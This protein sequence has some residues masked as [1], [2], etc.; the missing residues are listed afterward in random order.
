M[1]ILPVSFATKQS[2]VL[3]LL[4]LTTALIIAVSFYLANRLIDA[5]WWVEHTLKVEREAQSALVCLMDCE[6]A[7]RGFLITGEKQYLEP[8]EVCWRHVAGHVESLG[9]LTADNPNQQFRIPQLMELANR[10]IKF[11]QDVIEARR[12]SPGTPARTLLSLEPGRQ[13]MDEFRA[14]IAK[15]VD[16]EENLL[17][18]RNGAVKALERSTYIMVTALAGAVLLNLVWVANMSRRFAEDTEREHK[19]TVK[20]RNDAIEANELK[21]QFVS[22]ISHEIRTPMS[23]VLGLAEV[24]LMQPELSIQTKELVEQLFVAGKQLLS[25]LNQLLD[26]SKLEA[27]NA[28]LESIEF[29]IE[30]VLNGVVDLLKLN[31]EGKG[32][33]LTVTVAADVPKTIKGD[34]AK[35]RQVLLNLV[36]NAI[37]FTDEGGIE[38]KVDYL[39]EKQHVRFAVIDTGIGIAPEVQKNLFTPFIQ[40][41]ASTQRK[42]GGSGLG[43]SIGKKYVDLMSGT[44]DLKSSAGEGTA[45]WFSIPID[46]TVATNVP[47]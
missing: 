10:K 22:T 20:A 38:V 4:G 18:I 47:G 41:D 17:H 37:K 42:Y 1:A 15:I 34:E 3:T 11:S 19:L 5:H 14:G 27:G 43:L 24:V 28:Q 6:T 21:T 7:Y 2:W 32:L 16:E 23:G 13:I 29:P 31:A 44:I 12:K 25:V 33:K 35:L 39:P 30:G 26:F 46:I 9:R 36:H 45:V 8:Y 40:A